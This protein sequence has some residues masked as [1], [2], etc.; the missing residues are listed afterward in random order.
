MISI[1]P[2]TDGKVTGT[3]TLTV[4]SM[5]LGGIVITADGTNAAVVKLQKDDASGD[6]LL[7]VSSNTSFAV[8]APIATLTSS[9][10][11]SITGTGASAQ[12]YQWNE[13]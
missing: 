8:I 10:Y 5:T 12:I 2:L 1:S 9:V 11:Y 6:I 4:P 13:D 7:E 3:G